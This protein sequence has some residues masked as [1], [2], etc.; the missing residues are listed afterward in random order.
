MFVNLLSAHL[1][2]NIPEYPASP[3]GSGVVVRPGH[4]WQ[5]ENPPLQLG[6]RGREHHRFGSSLQLMTLDVLE[7]LDQPPRRRVPAAATFGID[8]ETVHVPAEAVS[9]SNRTQIGPYHYQCQKM[10][11]CSDFSDATS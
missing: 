11:V 4:T 6:Q 8:P 10:I 7:D 2:R 3:V 5:P 9:R 1:G